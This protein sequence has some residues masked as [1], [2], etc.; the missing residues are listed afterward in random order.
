[1]PR[2]MALVVVAAAALVVGTAHAE[3][4]TINAVGDVSF[5]RDIEAEVARRGGD[6]AWPLSFVAQY[7]GDADLTIVN[8][9]TTIHDSPPPASAMVGTSG[10]SSSARALDAIVAAGVDAVTLANNHM[11]DFGPGGVAST[12]AAVERAG[13]AHAG[14]AGAPWTVLEAGGARVGLLAAVPPI[15]SRLGSTSEINVYRDGGAALLAQVDALREVSD[16]V[17]V[18]VHCCVEYTHSPQNEKRALA[19]ALVAHGADVV[20]G[21]HPHVLQPP[22]N[23]TAVDVKTGEAREGTVVFSLG[24]FLFDSHLKKGGVRDSVLLRVV[25]DLGSASAG[26]PAPK[27]SFEYMPCVIHPELGYVPVPTGPFQSDFPTVETSFAND[28]QRHVKCAPFGAGRC[29][30]GNNT[31]HKKKKKKKQKSHV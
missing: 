9:E 24:N 5:S 4:I 27:F 25:V 1:M 2:R 23:I 3:R 22:E 14:T 11:N 20:L 10:F 13:L 31:T 12:V 7:L 26:G 17:I 16:V 6:Y 29:I 15:F 28:L 18:A 19:A 21:H 30:H 8:L